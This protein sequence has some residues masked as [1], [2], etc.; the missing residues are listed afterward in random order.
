MPLPTLFRPRPATRR[1]DPFDTF[2]RMMQRMFEDLPVEAAGEGYPVDIREEDGHL[3]VDAEMPGF[4][5][6]EINISVADDMLSIEAERSAE[7]P[8]GRPHLQERRFTRVQRSFRLPS[9]VDPE[10][11]EAKLDNG[12]LHIDMKET[13]SERIRKIEVK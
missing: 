6:D 3:I 13:E 7:S 10:S 8:K 2:E 9:A 12:V 11:V 5:R 4:N 1:A